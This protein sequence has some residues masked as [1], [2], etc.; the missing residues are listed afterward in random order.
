MIADIMP[1]WDTTVLAPLSA[2]GLC[3]LLFL[4]TSIKPNTKLKDLGVKRKIKSLRRKLRT[5]FDRVQSV[6]SDA[7]GWW[8]A[9]AEA[10]VDTVDTLAPRPNI[11]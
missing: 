11:D 9:G 10:A 3:A 4:M 7:G 6:N 1:A 2:N 5:A 8:A